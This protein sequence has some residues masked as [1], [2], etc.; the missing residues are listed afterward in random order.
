MDLAAGEAGR[1]GG[2]SEIM[3][4]LESGKY[5]VRT[6]GRVPSLT[7]AAAAPIFGV[8]E[9]APAFSTADSSAVGYSPRRVA[10]SKSGDESPHSERPVRI[11]VVRSSGLAS[12]RLWRWALE[13]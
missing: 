11:S 1:V 2:G 3:T 6:R 12:R 5:G 10:A 9:L 13:G 4:R 7:G 8:R